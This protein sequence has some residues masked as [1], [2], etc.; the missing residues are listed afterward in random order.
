M[1][2]VWW[3]IFIQ[4]QGEQEGGSETESP[5]WNR[6]A[7]WLEE[8]AHP[9]YHYHLM[10]ALIFNWTKFLQMGE[11]SCFFP[12]LFLVVWWRYFPR[13]INSFQRD[14]HAT[15]DRLV[16]K[17]LPVQSKHMYFHVFIWCTLMSSKINPRVLKGWELWPSMI[18]ILWH[19]FILLL[20]SNGRSSLFSPSSVFMLIKMRCSSSV[21]ITTR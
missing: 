11:R 2:I 12:F 14:C 5:N 9:I 17:S 6:F 20:S 1:V 16:H 8:S 15:E 21:N 18:V 19:P 13:I 3:L 4:N 10:M 7:L